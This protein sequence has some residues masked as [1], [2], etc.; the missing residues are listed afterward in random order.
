MILFLEHNVIL[1]AVWVLPQ[2]TH[3]ALL[4]CARGAN[5]LRFEIGDAWTGFPILNIIWNTVF[6][7]SVRCYPPE[8]VGFSYFLLRRYVYCLS[9]R[10]LPTP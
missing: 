5:L 3:L 9:T 1:Y 2:N 10:I 8:V 4:L 7:F 6:Y